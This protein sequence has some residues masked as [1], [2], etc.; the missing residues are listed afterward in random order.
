MNQKIVMRNE[1]REVE[2]HATEQPVEIQQ[3]TIKLN[4]AHIDLI[5]KE[6]DVDRFQATRWLKKNEG[7]LQ[8]TIKWVI[9]N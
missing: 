4:E 8:K 7:D 5:V 1:D 2:G 3:D 6:F 9:N